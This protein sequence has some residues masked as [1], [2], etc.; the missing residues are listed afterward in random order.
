MG[1][2]SPTDF[3]P[4]ALSNTGVQFQVDMTSAFDVGTDSDLI[5]AYGVSYMDEEYDVQ[6]ST[7]VNSYLAGPH[8]LSDP[9]DFCDDVTGLPTP[10]GAAI[11][12]AWPLDCAN[13]QDPAFTVVGVGSNGFPGYSPEFSE[14][15]SRDSYAV[16][17]ELSTD[18]TEN[19]FIQAA[20]RFE[21]YSDFGNETVAKLAGRY[22]VTDNVALRGSVGTGFRAPT[23]GQQ[24]TTNVSTRLPNGFPVATGLFPASGPVAQALGAEL[25]KPETSTSYTFGITADVGELTFSME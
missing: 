24:G 21:D 16:Y 3:K 9:Y 20:V 8:S 1:R 15:Y 2:A 6:Q 4:G 17:G 5:F 7:D 13:P 23:P 22:R 11:T 18:I 12:S 25:L 10:A 19:F 14:K